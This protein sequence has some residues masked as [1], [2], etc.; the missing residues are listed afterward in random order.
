MKFLQAKTL[1]IAAI[2]AFAASTAAVADSITLDNANQTV[3]FGNGVTVSF[4]GTFTGNADNILQD[5]LVTNL[6]LCEVGQC[7]TNDGFLLLF[8]DASNGVA[9]FFDIFVD[10]SVGPGL[11][12][13]QF[14]LQD[15][16][17]NV[18]SSNDFSIDVE[19]PE[20]GS[21]ALLGSGLLGLGGVLR[22]K[23]IA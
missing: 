13:G 7:L 8:G 23:L 21:I 22:R 17:G 16:D 18:V 4:T 19:T 6:P 9:S 11:Y 5:S 1:I 20:P 12:T 10:A 3:I 14:Q 2:F 15:G